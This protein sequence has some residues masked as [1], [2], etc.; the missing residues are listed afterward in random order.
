MGGKLDH[1]LFAEPEPLRV[2]RQLL[3]PRR[4]DV[5]VRHRR[6]APCELRHQHFLGRASLGG[7]PGG[8]LAKP[9]RA[10]VKR[11]GSAPLAKPRAEIVFVPRFAA[12]RNEEIGHAARRVRPGGE[13]P[14]EPVDDVE[15]GKGAGLFGLEAD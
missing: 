11:D 4:P 13:R 8:A 10:P 12:L 9:M 2:P 1:V 7:D 6:A 14:P 3:L 15:L 5:M